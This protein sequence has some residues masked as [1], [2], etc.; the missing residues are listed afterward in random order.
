VACGQ[1]AESHIPVSGRSAVAVPARRRQS[2]RDGSVNQ[3]YDENGIMP[4]EA[5]ESGLCKGVHAGAIGIISRRSRQ[6]DW[7][8]VITSRGA[9]QLACSGGEDRV[10]RL[11]IACYT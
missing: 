9:G 3:H 8:A 10:F 7:Q 11:A 5:R 1:G 6:I 4:G 2:A